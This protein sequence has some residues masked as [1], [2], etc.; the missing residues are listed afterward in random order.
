MNS[1]RHSKTA[2]T[3]T[4]SDIAAWPQC[5]LRSG[6]EVGISLQVLWLCRALAELQTPAAVLLGRTGLGT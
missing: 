5:D 4:R 2:A 3:P 6:L 1:P